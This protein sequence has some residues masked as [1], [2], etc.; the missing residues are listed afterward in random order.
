MSSA[1]PLLAADVVAAV[2][3]WSFIPHNAIRVETDEYQVLRLPDWWEQPLELRWIRPARP[4]EIV[5]D[6]VIEGCRQS[7]LPHVCCWVRLDP[8]AGL[9]EAL[10]AW[11]GRPDETLDVLARSLADGGPDLDPPAIEVRWATDETTFADAMRVG[12]LV[13]GGE[14]GADAVDETV[15]AEEFAQ[16]RGKVEAGGG[17]SV[18]AYVD[19]RPVGSAGITLDGPDARLWGGGVVDDMRGR[20]I[21]RALLAERLR[22]AVEHG[23]ELAL[24]KGRVE[25]SGPILRRAGFEVFGQE[26]SYLVPLPA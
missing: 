15:V 13:F 5:L 12:G 20:G 1:P 26:R 25:T 23:A 18:V 7:G 19:G 24:V 10:I 16:E 9:E 14:E 2:G 4:L 21:Y 8:P 17:G 3:R 11:G 22:Y 6:E